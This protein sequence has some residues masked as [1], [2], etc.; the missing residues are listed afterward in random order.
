MVFQRSR[1]D[2]IICTRYASMMETQIVVTIT[3]SFMTDSTI[4]GEDLMTLKFQKSA[5]KMSSR[6]LKVVI[7]GKLPIG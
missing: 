6:S 3:L 2:L 5:K 4:S 1:K 7:P